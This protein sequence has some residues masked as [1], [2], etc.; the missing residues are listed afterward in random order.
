M[1][2]ATRE[3]LSHYPVVL[4]RDMA[5]DTL[6]SDA[7]LRAEVRRLRVEVRAA[8]AA[9]LFVDQVAEWVERGA[10]TLYFTRGSSPANALSAAALSPMRKARR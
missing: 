3:R 7:R 2:H 1:R 6:D 8:Q 5:L 4:D 10:T 9:R